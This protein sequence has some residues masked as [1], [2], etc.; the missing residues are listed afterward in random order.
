M[1]TPIWSNTEIEILKDLCAQNKPLHTLVS[2]LPEKSET[3]IRA[4]CKALNISFKKQ[5]NYWSEQELKEFAKDWKDPSLSY[6]KLR[7]KYK[8]R[9]KTAL[10]S[11]AARL[12]LGERPIDDSYLTI[13]DI[14]T[15]MHV[16]KDRVRTWIRHGLKYHKSRIKPVKYLID[17]KELLD[18]L[19]EHPSYY[20]AS[21]ISPYLFSPEPIWLK[22][23][24]KS[25]KKDFRKRSKASEYYNDA[26]CKQIITMFKQGKSNAEIATKLNR[27]AYGIERMLSMLG[28][29]RK[30]YN[31]YEIQIIKDNLE[32]HTIDEIV[33]MLPL[34]T[35]SGVIAKCEQ[36]K[37]KYHS[38][39]G[40]V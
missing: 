20:D 36:L 18:F 35:K 11:C 27:T 1:A 7:E 9:S 14:M 39:K 28:Y 32:S 19:K 31:D 29:S 23:K 6:A 13:S 34:R 24:R 33:D 8:N 15:E 16:S 21:T 5:R 30:R 26:E 12:H 2:A 3:Q 22:E 40:D 25:D 38:K 4:K 37:L 10:I 17:T